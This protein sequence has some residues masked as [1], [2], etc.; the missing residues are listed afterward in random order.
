MEF[1]HRGRGLGQ[2]RRELTEGHS[3][4]T[5]IYVLYFGGNP[6]FRSRCGVNDVEWQSGRPSVSRRIS[7]P[8]SSQFEIKS[9]AI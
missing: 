6:V 2:K 9:S 3:V 1:D 4:D 8:C 7:W 5:M